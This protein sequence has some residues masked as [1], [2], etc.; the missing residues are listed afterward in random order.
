MFRKRPVS[1]GIDTAF[2]SDFFKNN[3]ERPVFVLGRTDV[4]IMMIKKCLDKW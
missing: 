2:G 3:R 4:L 1:R